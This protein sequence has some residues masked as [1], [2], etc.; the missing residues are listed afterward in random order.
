V[1]LPSVRPT[2]RN[3]FNKKKGSTEEMLEDSNGVIRNHKRKDR[4]Y[5]D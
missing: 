4:Q 1:K 5:N 3:K 2:L